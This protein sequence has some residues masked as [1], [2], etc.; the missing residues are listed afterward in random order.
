M[1]NSFESSSELYEKCFKSY[2]MYGDTP[3]HMHMPI[4]LN[5][6]DTLGSCL[7][8]LNSEVMKLIDIKPNLRILEL[9]CG[10]GVLS[11]RISKTFDAEVI[12]LSSSQSEIDSALR[13]SRDLGVEDKCEFLLKDMNDVTVD[14]FG[15]FDLI[16]NVESECYFESVEK[17][18]D[19][20]S[21]L[22]V[23]GGCWI[24][25]RISK[26]DTN[27]TRSCN[28]TAKLIEEGWAMSTIESS[29]H[30]N[31]YCMKFFNVNESRAYGNAIVKYWD[32]LAPINLSCMILIKIRF[33][34]KSFRESS[35]FFDFRIVYN[36][37]MAFV[38]LVK[39]LKREGCLD[40]RLHK[41][42]KSTTSHPKN[43][44][45]IE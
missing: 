8:N 31:Q 11:T 42:V 33:L 15:K 23:D 6:E 37:R 12:G 35:D 1:I 39:A 43:L 9:G 2:S 20:V 5:H 32:N 16:L 29:S 22:L 19:T 25:A 44:I 21:E 40:Y 17:A 10:R 30:F 28:R 13:A 7:E 4:W 27:Q 26:A 38:Y 34:W 36:H 3:G 24:T 45:K 18:V 41:L 14:S